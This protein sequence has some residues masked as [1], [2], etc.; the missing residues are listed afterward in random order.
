MRG[1]SMRGEERRCQQRFTHGSWYP[2]VHG[3]ELETASLNPPKPKRE[4][5]DRLFKA[6]FGRDTEESK[7]WRLDLYNEAS[8][9][10]SQ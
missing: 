4:Y 2:P 1:S 8:L 7:R 9:A 6:I 3:A 5:K 10:G